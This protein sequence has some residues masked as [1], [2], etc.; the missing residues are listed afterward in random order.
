VTPAELAPFRD[1]LLR[2]GAREAFSAAQYAG[3]LA[4]MAKRVGGQPLDATTLAQAISIVQA[5]HSAHGRDS[6]PFVEQSSMQT[7]R[8]W[9]CC[10]GVAAHCRH[11][12]V[13]QAAC[14]HDSIAVNARANSCAVRNLSEHLL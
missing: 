7:L 12:A 9:F 13:T 1:L 10:A 4:A 5:R 14:E 3:V 6:H 8:M 11:K 2:L